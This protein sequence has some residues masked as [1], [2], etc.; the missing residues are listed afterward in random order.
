M[1]EVR[2]GFDST[3]SGRAGS[4]ADDCRP[5]PDSAEAKRIV[6]NLIRR[7][8]G[9]ATAKPSPSRRVR[10]KPQAKL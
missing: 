9:C 2:L 3:R 5:C 10:A 7:G 1:S 8:R 6:L 4:E